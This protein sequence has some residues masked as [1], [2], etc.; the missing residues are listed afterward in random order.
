MGLRKAASQLLLHR[1]TSICTCLLLKNNTL[2][3]L[4]KILSFVW[5]FVQNQVKS[6]TDN[7]VKKQNFVDQTCFKKSEMNRNG[8]DTNVDIYRSTRIS[9]STK[10][11]T[12]NKPSENYTCKINAHPTRDLES[13]YTCVHASSL[14]RIDSLLSVCYLKRYRSCSQELNFQINTY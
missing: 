10:E 9:T 8:I 14:H 4:L 2:L 7:L 1:P 5:W 6:F 11:L 12:K 13:L 3:D